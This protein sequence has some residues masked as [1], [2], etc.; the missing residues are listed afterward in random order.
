MNFKHLLLN[1]LFHGHFFPDSEVELVQFLQFACSQLS[2]ISFA[3]RRGCFHILMSIIHL[4]FCLR[5]GILFLP[6][7]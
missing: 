4:Q 2:E 3:F 6:K 5:F 1:L 7:V